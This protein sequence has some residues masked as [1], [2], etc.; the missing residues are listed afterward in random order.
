MENKTESAT[1]RKAKTPGFPMLSLEYC[2]QMEELQ[3]KDINPFLYHFETR[4]E[5]L[6]AKMATCKNGQFDKEKAL[7]I[8]EEGLKYISEEVFPACP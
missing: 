4:F 1:K 6:C 3:D 8:W 7:W 5:A 2:K